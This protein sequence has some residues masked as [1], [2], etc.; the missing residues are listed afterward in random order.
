MAPKANVGKCFRDARKG[1]GIDTIADAARLLGTQE[2]TLS[3]IEGGK[4]KPTHRLLI[5]CINLYGTTADFLLGM[6]ENIDND[7]DDSRERLKEAREHAAQRRK[8]TEEK[9]Q[10]S[11]DLA[12][13]TESELKRL[14]SAIE[15]RHEAL[16]QEAAIS[17]IER[18]AGQLILAAT[19][20]AST[21]RGLQKPNL[22]HDAAAWRL[23]DLADSMDRL[24]KDAEAL[25]E[26]L[27]AARAH[28]SDAGNRGT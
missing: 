1:A 28:E 11:I 24:Q 15:T 12:R 16:L 8:R 19:A 18:D 20:A 25:R 21:F 2:S 7:P 3:K 23:D 6:T 9:A 26:S 14:A 13:Q 27:T 10:E 22:T 5:D 17:A 4:S